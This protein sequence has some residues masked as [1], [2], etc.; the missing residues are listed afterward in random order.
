MA[1][2]IVLPGLIPGEMVGVAP[3]VAITCGSVPASL[4]DASATGPT[5]Q[6]AGDRFL[7]HIPG[8]ARFLLVDGREI[9]VEL[10][11]DTPAEQ[12]AIFLVGTV[13]G[14][15][16]HQRGQIV[17]HAS[18]IRVGGKAV[19]FCGPSGA[20]KST[21]AAALGQLGYPLVSDDLCAVIADAKDGPL[22]QPDGR[23]L[24]LWSQA[25]DQL[26][27]SERRGGAVRNKLEKF[28]VEPG[29][30]F[31][32]ALP[33]GALYALREARPPHAPGITRPNVVDCTLLLRRNAYRPFL[34]R[35]FGQKDEYFRAAAAM[36]NSA[37]FFHLTRALDFAQMPEV[38]GW[39]RDHWEKLGL[40]EPV[41]R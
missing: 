31:G 4:A 28:Y 33:L 35:R 1:S 9:K 29:D 11:D 41:G 6:I 38:L 5:W 7:L 25:I 2:E 17:L 26:G 19:L 36:A 13:F 14:I 3:A 21:I 16:L 24:K 39:L 10:E 27:L 40:L 20:G 18:A 22:V 15:L 30:A 23:Q 12:V 32:E 37:G 8:V 34:V